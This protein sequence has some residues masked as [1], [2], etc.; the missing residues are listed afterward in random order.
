MRNSETG[1]IE[2]V[3]GN[4]QLLSTFFVVVLL[5]GAAF[6]M[7]Y[8]LGENSRSAKTSAE[9]GGS[10]SVPVTGSAEA[11]PQ[12]GGPVPTPPAPTPDPAAQQP[13]AQEQPAATAP[14]EAVP[15]PTTQPSKELQAEK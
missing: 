2:I 11:R 3:V 9:L 15:E 1:E 6:V 12:P 13:A 4:K 7:G 10:P 5:C 8:F 14:A